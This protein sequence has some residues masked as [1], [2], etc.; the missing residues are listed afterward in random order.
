M[1]TD[2]EMIREFLMEIP[3]GSRK[4]RTQCPV[5]GPHRRKR[6]EK[7]LSVKFDGHSAVFM[8]HHCEA[9]GMVDLSFEEEKIEQVDVPGFT[10]EHRKR[11]RLGVR[12][13]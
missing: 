4:S 6:N 3:E 11:R 1:A 13:N 12:H 5:C 2:T 9:K 8:C 7:T 10:V